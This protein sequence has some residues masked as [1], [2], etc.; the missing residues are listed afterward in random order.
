MVDVAQLQLVLLHA[1][2]AGIGPAR[3]SGHAAAYQYSWRHNVY[4]DRST[5]QLWQPNVVNNE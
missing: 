5:C 3:R 2:L 4:G 1:G